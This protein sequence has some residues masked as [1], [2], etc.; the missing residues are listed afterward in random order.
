LLKDKFRDLVSIRL[1]KPGS[2]EEQESWDDLMELV[3]D[4]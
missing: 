3:G 4:V 1:T 2:A